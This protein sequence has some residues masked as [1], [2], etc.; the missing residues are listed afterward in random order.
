MEASIEAYIQDRYLQCETSQNV[1][2]QGYQ[3]QHEG[4][5]LPCHRELT[6]ILFDRNSFVLNDNSC[7]IL[8]GTNLGLPIDRELTAILFG[9]NSFAPLRLIKIL[10]VLK[11][12]PDSC[13]R[14]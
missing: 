11:L 2:G 10:R 5:G 1:F 9:R 6:G 3:P 4:H 14:V 8:F 12:L 13:L 7:V